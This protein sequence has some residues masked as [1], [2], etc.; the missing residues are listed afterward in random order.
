VSIITISRYCHSHGDEIAKKVAQQLDYE[1]ASRRVILEASEE[2]NIEELKLVR[3]IHDA[4][5][6]FDRLSLE[7]EKY[8]S[9][10][11]S[12]LLKHF[13]KDNVVYHGLAGH[14]FVGNV[15][16][17]LKVRII[18]DMN[19]RVRLE[20]EQGGGRPERA[21]ENLR[22]DDQ[23][24]RSWSQYLYGIDS[25]DFKL[26]DLVINLHRVTVDHAVEI[27]CDTARLEEFKT[28]SESQKILDDLVTMSEIE[29]ILLEKGY[30]F[31]VKNRQ[32]EYY[33]NVKSTMTSERMLAQEIKEILKDTLALE[34][35][36]VS[37]A[38]VVS[39][40]E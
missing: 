3:A 24:R 29:S 18:A 8:I 17:A 11:K 6:I 31:N 21:L 33:I 37:K 23:Q 40:T 2:F 1:S 27:I 12:A 28:T 19:E 5:S 34:K 22:K 36:H 39:L 7:K 20:I 32:G 4:P 14:F 35:V 15:P 9:F 16:H 26:Y 25:E 10:I 38:H 13:Q 30:N